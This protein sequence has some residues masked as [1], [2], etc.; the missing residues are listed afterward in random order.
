MSQNH[1]KL[2]NLFHNPHNKDP[3]LLPRS[4]GMLPL[5]ELPQLSP[6]NCYSE[7]KGFIIFLWGRCGCNNHPLFQ[8]VQQLRNRSPGL[9]EILSSP[10]EK[11]CLCKGEMNQ[12]FNQASCILSVI[13]HPGFTFIDSSWCVRAGKHFIRHLCI[14]FH[15]LCKDARGKKSLSLLIEI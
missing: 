3:R 12:T 15:S 1:L 6:H 8:L 11:P 5:P 4:P 14:L 10:P 2:R 7:L 9:K 13:W